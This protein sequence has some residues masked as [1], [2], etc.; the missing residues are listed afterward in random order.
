MADWE[1]GFSTV[2]WWFQ[3]KK[4]DNWPGKHK[5]KYVFAK[6][7]KFQDNDI[8][9]SQLKIYFNLEIQ[10]WNSNIQSWGWENNLV[11]WKIVY[12]T[13]TVKIVNWDRNSI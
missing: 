6:T 5:K 2:F 13:E 8:H 7:W 12:E 11:C 1:F 4:I 10:N 9:H 3:K